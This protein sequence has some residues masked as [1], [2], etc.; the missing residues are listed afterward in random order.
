MAYLVPLA[1]FDQQ[2]HEHARLLAQFGNVEA[3]HE[4]RVDVR[5]RFL[6]AAPGYGLPKQADFEFVEWYRRTAQGW[7]RLRYRFEY[8]PVNS[9]RAHHMAVGPAVPHQHCEPPGRRSKTHYV[10]DERLLLPT[11]RELGDLFVYQRAIDCR[12]LRR[13]RPH[14]SAPEHDEAEED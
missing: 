1:A 8:R 13:L 3:S 2:L 7:L 5:T 4:G 14:S 10:D 9:R 12:G 11:A 6:V